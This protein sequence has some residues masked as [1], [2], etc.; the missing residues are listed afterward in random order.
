MDNNPK[1]HSC[2]RRWLIG[3]GVACLVIVI[4]LGVAS[5]YMLSY[6]L[7]PPMRHG[8]NLPWRLNN[9]LSQSPQLRPWADSLRRCHALRDTFITMPSGERHHA[10]YIVA[11]RP[12]DRVAVLVHGYK[13]NGMGMM[14]I[15]SIYSRL[16]YHLLLPDLHA[17]GRS[18]GQGVQMGWNDRLDV[19][20]WMEVANRRFG[21]GRDTRMVVHGVSMGAATTMN[22]SGEQLPAYVRCFVEDCGYTSVWDEFGYELRE[23]FHLPP[24]PLLYTSSALCRAKYGWSF[25]EASPLRQVARCHRPM[26]FIHGDRDT[27]VPFA[28][29]HQLYAA[30]PQ[31]KE[32]W[33]SPGS[34]HAMSFRDHPAEYTAR[35]SR[36]VNRYIPADEHSLVEK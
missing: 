20:R 16:G 25:G 22:V 27:Y 4:G 18:Q 21:Q 13:D 5:N 9:I 15:A 35:V 24:F 7:C 10:T 33:V 19:M 3:I 34:I 11:R 30:K 32:V 17:H 6:S 12:T 31:P 8:H 28:M 1:H 14:H 2:R 29:L 26:L 23:T 36:F